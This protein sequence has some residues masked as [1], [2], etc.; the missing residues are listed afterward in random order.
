MSNEVI[1]YGLMAV[2]GLFLIVIIA[3]IILMKRMNKADVKKAMAL[4]SGVESKSFS[5]D[6]IYQ[7]LYMFYIK[8]PVLKR[9]LVKLR[10]RLEIIN[11]EDEYLTRKQSAKILTNALLIIIP[12]TIFIIAFTSNNTLLLAILLIFEIFMIETIIGGMVDKMDNKLLKQQIN[13]FA[14]IRHAYHESNMVEEAIYQVA[15]DDELE[16]SRQAEKI[17]E[18]LISDDPEA[19]LEKYY[20]IAPNSY[21]KEFA[22]ISYLTREFGDRK[23]QNGASLYL[24]N[25]NNI[26]QEMQIEILKRDKL[27]YVF[28]S[29]SVIAAIP[30]LFIEPVKNWAVSQFSFTGQFY[31]GKGGLIV[32]TLILILTF[33]CYILIRKLK[34]NS[35]TNANIKNTENPWQAKLYKIREIRKI[36]DIFMPK[37]GTKEHRKITTLLK[38]AASKQKIEWLYINRIVLAIVTCVVSVFMFYQLHRISIQ[39]IVIF[40]LCISIQFYL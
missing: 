13:F 35:S 21:L 5:S 27:D 22:G 37:Q 33:I 38:D 6:V 24:K 31:N 26:T 14:E 10:R 25:L 32:Q 16:I 39:Y 7:K 28:Q 18:V 8:V 29:L 1:M 2:A 20:D 30:I 36:V 4:K 17:Y 9:Y 15:Q 23:D 19:E 40:Y 34:D 3:Y 12:L 11:I